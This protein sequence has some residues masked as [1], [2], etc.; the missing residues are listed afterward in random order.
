VLDR[1]G[2]II[3]DRGY[4]NDP[5]QLEFLPGA[6]EGLRLLH[7]QG[8]RLIV[9]TNQS[10]IGR[11][12]LSTEGLHKIHEHLDRMIAAVGARIEA[13][14]FC[15]HMPNAGCACRKP[16]PGLLTR[17]A[18]ELGFEVSSAI[19]VGD[20]TSDIELGQKAGI[21]AILISQDA[22]AQTASSA[23]DFVVGDLAA[24]ARIITRG[25]GSTP[26]RSATDLSAT[27]R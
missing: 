5:N 26:T 20:K 3:V 7:E 11:G 19:V 9:I 18:R 23:A 17:A 15:P 10:V 14:Y 6:V 16:S 22:C 8:F 4:L 21:P 13:Y 24:A 1:D 27:C 25:L 12:H 2:T